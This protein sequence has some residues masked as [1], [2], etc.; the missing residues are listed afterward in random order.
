MDIK[1]DFDEASKCWRRNKKALPKGYFAYVC[2]Y[3]KS[4]GNCCNKLVSDNN[5]CKKHY[6][7]IHLSSLK[8]K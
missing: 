3:V 2:E 8:H 5:Y 7:Y 1:I 4:N 6:K